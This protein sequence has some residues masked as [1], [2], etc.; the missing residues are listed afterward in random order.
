MEMANRAYPVTLKGELTATPSRG[1]WL[2][3]WLLAIPHFIILIF[4]W[5]AFAVVCVISFFAIL[6]TGKHPRG[7]FDFKLGVLRW[8]WRV[9]FYSYEALGTDRYPPFTLGPVP[10]YPATFDIPYP[11][12]LSRGLVLVKWWLLAIPHYIVVGIFWGG[13]GWNF[14]KIQAG[15][16]GTGLIFILA[17]FAGICLL[18]CGC[19]PKDL[20]KLLVG[21]NRWAYRVVAYVTLMTDAYPPFRLWD[22]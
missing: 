12:K 7:L 11:E 21:L 2:L 14:D 20:F 9:G 13:I 17:I 10:D 22:D 4:L 19:Y 8:S 1:W 16:G 18:F 5:I 6:F 15:G 3:K